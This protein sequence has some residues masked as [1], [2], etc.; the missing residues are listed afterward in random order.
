MNK[1]NSSSFSD[2]IQRGIDKRNKRLE[3]SKIALAAAMA[4]QGVKSGPISLVSLVS[5]TNFN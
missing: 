1:I 4:K 3:K 5:K 2:I